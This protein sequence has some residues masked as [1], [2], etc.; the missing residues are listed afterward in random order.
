[1]KSHGIK[2][3]T[4]LFDVPASNTTAINLLKNC[5]SQADYFFLSPDST[6]LN[7]A[8]KQIGDSL[9]NLRISK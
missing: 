8:F 3:Y 9:S 1:M 5:A 4:I 2:I 6:T 7:N